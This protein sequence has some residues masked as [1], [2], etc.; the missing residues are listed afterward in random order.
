MDSFSA[1][2][3]LMAL[4]MIIL[5]YKEGYDLLLIFNLVALI[6]MTLQITLLDELMLLPLAIMFGALT[7]SSL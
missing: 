7:I 4:V 2:V 6:N 5:R 1:V 3:L